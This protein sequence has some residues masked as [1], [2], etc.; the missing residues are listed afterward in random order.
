MAKTMAPCVY[1]DLS[2]LDPTSVRRRFPGIDALCQSFA[3]DITRDRIPVRPGAHYFIGGAQVDSNGRTS[4]PGLWAAG[5][6]T[7][8]GL[9]G[10]NRLASNSLLEGL[11]YGA[12]VADDIRDTLREAGPVRLEVP[13]I[14]SQPRPAVRKPLDLE[15]IRDSL[16]SL[17][18]R[19]VGIVRN[20]QG[21]GEAASQVDFWC[22]Y[23]LDQ[24]F[25]DPAG[26]SLQNM[27]VV[28][29]MMIA[30]AS[31]REESR[32]VHTRSDYPATEP[33]WRRHIELSHPDL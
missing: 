30:A 28:A 3:L 26:W 20:G 21:L 19:R 15:D 14:R 24:V 8:T 17:M 23:A 25:D 5:E 6:V 29:R 7:A 9:H 18:W 2:H 32:G 11:V 4:L 12:R 31:L 22:R 10:A 13:S 1:L 16:K 27:L 33:P